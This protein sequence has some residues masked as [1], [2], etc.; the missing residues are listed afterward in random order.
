M[1]SGRLKAELPGPARS[2]NPI[3]R[4]RRLHTADNRALTRVQNRIRVLEGEI[5]FSLGVR[6][7]LEAAVPAQQLLPLSSDAL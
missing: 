1:N 6:L 2:S 3:P 4:R 7:R 5:L